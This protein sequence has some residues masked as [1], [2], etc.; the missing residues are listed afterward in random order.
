MREPLQYNEQTARIAAKWQ[1]GLRDNARAASILFPLFIIILELYRYIS[2]GT[3][4]APAVL[5]TDAAV[6]LMFMFVLVLLEHKTRQT[7]Q[8]IRM[9]ALT[10]DFSADAVVIREG[11]AVVFSA[12]GDAIL[13][14]DAGERAVRFKTAYDAACV[15]K[16]QAPDALLESL[17]ER[18]GREYK[19]HRW[20]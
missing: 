13:A 11:D 3:V 6:I 17:R 14:V 20:M 15:P 1:L 2:Q 9:R 4:S 19:L 5:R 12:R 7:A 18:L 10:I 16:K 8:S